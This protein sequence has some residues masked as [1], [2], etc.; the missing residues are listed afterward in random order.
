MTHVPKITRS[1]AYMQT[2]AQGR[3]IRSGVTTRQLQADITLRPSGNSEDFFRTLEGSAP[4]PLP[5]QRLP[6]YTAG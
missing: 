4:R 3:S 5:L 1:P 2:R 6:A